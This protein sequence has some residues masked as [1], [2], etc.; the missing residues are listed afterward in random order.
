MS[1]LKDQPPRRSGENIG[2]PSQ[3]GNPLMELRN[4]GQ[5]IWLDNIRRQ[6]IAGG[7][8]ERLIADDHVTGI[9]S[10][11]SIFEK[12]IAGSTDY[13]DLLAGAAKNKDRCA[14]T[15]YEDLAIRD[16]QDAADLLRPIYEQ[17]RRLDGYVSLEVSPYLAHDAKGTV[18]EAHRLWDKVGR[19]NLLIK[20]PAAPEGVPAIRQLIA[21]GINVNVTLLFSRKVYEQVA[22]AYISALEELDSR[23]GDLSRM[24]GVAS[25]FV[26]RIDSSIDSLVESRLAAATNE[27]EKTR[28]RSIPGR[29]AIANAKLV[30]QEFK[31]IFGGK[32]WQVLAAKGAR[33]QRLL[34]A[35]T[36]TKNPNYRDVL[37]VEELIG[38]DTVNTLPPAT[39]DAFREHGHSRPS[40]EENIDDA[41][42][43]METLAQAGISMDEITDKLLDDGVRLFAGAFDRL[44]AAVEKKRIYG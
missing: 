39:L 21:D 20:V 1:P 25:F 36:S 17:T 34:W 44:L 6:L 12:A 43:V 33:V 19:E 32:R 22:D 26:S 30:Y 9:T 2:R 37:Y 41:R 15:L 35:S 24:A 29:V 14:M 11:P 7:E 16:I 5:S 8:L 23:G 13:D 31:E 4:F 3:A 27:A 42:A 28:L 38:R 40:L 18:T 10:N